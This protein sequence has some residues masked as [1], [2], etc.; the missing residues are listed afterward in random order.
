V[1]RCSPLHAIG[2]AAV[3]GAVGAAVLYIGVNPLT[4]ALGVFN[5]ALYTS[6]YTPM[7]RLSIAN[8]WV[9][10]IV[11]A[12]PPLM[13]WAASAGTLHPGDIL[14]ECFC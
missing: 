14:D 8:T 9:G 1:Q 10:S 5:L 2:F 13:G 4:A 7:K 11:G 6:V 3:S 12:I